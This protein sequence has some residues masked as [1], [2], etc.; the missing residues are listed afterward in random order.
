M[1][2]K[3]TTAPRQVIY[4]DPE[5]EA[6][7]AARRN[8]T[9]D[10]AVQEV[11]YLQRQYHMQW[12]PPMST[13]VPDLNLILRTLIQ[14]RIPFVL[15]GA[16][17]IAGWTGKPRNTH[18]VDILVKGGRNLTRAVNAIHALY[19]ELEIRTFFGVTGFFEPGKKESRIDVTY[20]HR[21]D[22]AETL[23]HPVW[24]DN[25]ELGLRY[26]VPTLEAALANKYGAMLA[27]S[28]DLDKRTQDIVDFMRMVKHSSDEGRQPIDLDRLQVLGEQVWP[29]GG[30]AEILRL[31][32]RVKANL[33]IELSS[34]GG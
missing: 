22:I 20:P 15:T 3:R 14:K 18:D 16:H 7:K 13:F 24:T 4:S 2:M 5:W 9:H 6:A 26:R 8:L 27:L 21:A 10:D 33:P 11:A 34:L 23:E 12:G 29:G 31:V 25:A 30:G 28:R 17:G 19:P 32:E 1:K